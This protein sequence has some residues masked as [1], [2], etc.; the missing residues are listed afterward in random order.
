MMS[1]DASPRGDASPHFSLTVRLESFT[2]GAAAIANP[3]AEGDG[4]IAETAFTSTNAACGQA[5][6]ASV[7]R[8]E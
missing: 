6:I 5:R 1:T 2:T 8:E 4:G 7:D 3:I